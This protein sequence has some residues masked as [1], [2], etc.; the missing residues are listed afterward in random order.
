VFQVAATA[1]NPLVYQWNKDGIPVDSATN[2]VLAL[3]DVQPSQAG[4]Y[5]VAISNGLTGVL[6]GSAA[7]TV[8]SS[9]GAGGPRFLSNQFGF[10]LSGATGSSFVIEASSDLRSWT[11]LSTNTFGNGP[12]QFVDPGSSTNP[13]GFYRVR[14]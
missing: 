2:A 9:T 11:P 10:S 6:S 5:G 13:V 8:M 3:T 1:Q 4:L 7:L 14:Y 12:F